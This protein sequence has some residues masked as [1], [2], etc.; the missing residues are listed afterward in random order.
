MKWTVHYTGLRRS[1]SGGPTAAQTYKVINVNS[2][3]DHMDI[4]NYYEHQK[5]SE[6]F[7]FDM[8]CYNFKCNI[9]Q[10]LI[11]IPLLDIVSSCFLLH[12]E[13]NLRSCFFFPT[14][15]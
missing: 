2:R 13:V 6:K 12:F 10:S 15:I 1:V 4:Y 11:K 14:W 9:C 3:N 8:C 5:T 7:H